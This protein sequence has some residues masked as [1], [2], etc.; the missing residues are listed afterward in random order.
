MATL[1]KF[2]CSG[3]SVNLCPCSIYVYLLKYFDNKSNYC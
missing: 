3:E 1:I 2:P